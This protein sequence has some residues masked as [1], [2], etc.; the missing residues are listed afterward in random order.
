MRFLV[1]VK[2]EYNAISYHRLKKPF[3]YLQK[4]GHHCDF[5]YNFTN[6]V[7]I[8]GYDYFVY[9]R[10]IGYGDADFGLLEKIKSQGIKIIIDV[11]DLWE[12]PEN[13]PIVWRTDVDYNGWK[14]NFLMNIAFADYVWTSTDYLKMIIE[15]HFTNKPVVVVKNAIDYDDP[16]WMDNKGKKKNKNKTVIGYAGSTTHYGDLDQMKTPLRRLNRNKYVKRNMVFQL[17][18]TDFI[19]D[20][21]KKVWHHQLGIFTD[22]GKNNNV[23]ISGGVRVNQYARF[24]D[25]M[26][27]VIAPLL[28]ND[29]NRCKSEL[30]VLEAGAKW[31]PFIGS[32]MVTFSRTG[33]N[34]DLCSNGDEWVESI[35]EL[36]LDKS[37]RESLGKELGE[38]VRDMYKIDKE[39]Q[40]RLS[41]L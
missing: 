1:C 24:F 32:D 9:N 35:L 25:Q 27:I 28:D 2:S 4:E 33:A 26:D 14:N 34:I 3:E 22:D 13:H 30:K 17:S 15:D 40:A 8:E 19:N 7:V 10:S 20:Y 23:F 6:D 16:Q 11:D 41:I 36:S 5:I 37:L 18:G 38:Y 29:F 12:L 21:G 31:L 39:N